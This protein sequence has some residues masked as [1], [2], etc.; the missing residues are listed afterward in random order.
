TS[1]E[2]LFNRY[3]EI[4]RQYMQDE[5]MFD[6]AMASAILEKKGISC[7]N[8]DYRMFFICM[9]YAESVNWGNTS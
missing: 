4:Y 8:F 3:T 5:R 7:P 1:L 6:T 9:R 2:I